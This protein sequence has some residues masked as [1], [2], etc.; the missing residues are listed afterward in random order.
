VENGVILVTI[1]S[2]GQNS[3]AFIGVFFE[4]CYFSTIYGIENAG[5]FGTYVY[6]CGANAPYEIKNITSH[7][8][9]S[10]VFMAHC[11]VKHCDFTL[12]YIVVFIFC[13]ADNYLTHTLVARA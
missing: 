10:C 12:T 8:S 5:I 13:V 2:L 7:Q 4:G 3:L 6:C 9:P 1:C 11:L